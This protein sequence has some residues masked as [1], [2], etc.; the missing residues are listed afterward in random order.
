MADAMSTIALICTDCGVT[1]LRHPSM[2]MRR[3]ICLECQ[4]KKKIATRMLRRQAEVST[5]PPELAS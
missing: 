3:V 4:K 5:K 1:L 2:R